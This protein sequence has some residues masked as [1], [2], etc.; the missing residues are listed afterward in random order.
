MSCCETTT[1]SS[2]SAAI[3]AAVVGWSLFRRPDERS[4]SLGAVFSFMNTLVSGALLREISP[5]SKGETLDKSA[6][7]IPTKLWFSVTPISLSSL[8]QTS[9]SLDQP[10]ST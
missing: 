2:S 4:W 5:L 10:M 3:V 8:R 6:T 9:V 1:G 7:Q